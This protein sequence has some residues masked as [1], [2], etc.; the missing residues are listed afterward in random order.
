[1]ILYQ[2]N[3]GEIQGDNGTFH[4]ATESMVRPKVFSKSSDI[5]ANSNCSK[6]TWQKPPNR[7]SINYDLATQSVV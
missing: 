3:K 6:I 4:S 5:K 7:G 2:H 1:M